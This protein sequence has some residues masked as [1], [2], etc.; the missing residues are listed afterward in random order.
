MVRLREAGEMSQE[1]RVALL[2]V[3]GPATLPRGSCS[4]AA[5]DALL[6]LGC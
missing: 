5:S 4:L 2:H 1:M 6:M 3:L